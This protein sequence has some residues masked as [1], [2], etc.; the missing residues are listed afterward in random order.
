MAEHEPESRLYGH[1]DPLEVLIRSVPLDQ[2]LASIHQALYAQIEIVDR[3]SVVA[4]DPATD[5]L[6]T[7]LAS[8]PGRALRSAPESGGT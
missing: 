3:I 4:Y 1:A 7:F 8:S 2:K 6:K 5:L